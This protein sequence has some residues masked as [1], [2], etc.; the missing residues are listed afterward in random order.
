MAV[1]KTTLLLNGKVHFQVIWMSIGREPSCAISCSEEL[2]LFREQRKGEGRSRNGPLEPVSL[3][4][5]GA[6]TYGTARL[7]KCEE[8]CVDQ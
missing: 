8:V 7:R 2:A 6:L 5:M 4:S 3:A 1:G